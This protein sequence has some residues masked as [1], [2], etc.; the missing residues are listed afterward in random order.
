MSIYKD[1]V[2]IQNQLFGYRKDLHR[3]PELGL[4]LPMT[5]EYIE[6][7][8]REMGY[9]PKRVGGCG[10]TASI[11]KEGGKCFMLR[12]DMD[13]LP[14]QELTD[15]EYKSLN[16]NMH[17]C[18]H[19]CHKASML[20]AAQLLKMHEAELDGMVKFMFQP[21]EE[22][23]EGAAMMIEEGILENPK[24]DA[25]LGL[26]IF[27]GMPFPAGTVAMMGADGIF[28][29][30]DWF[31]VHIKGVGCHGAMPNRGVDP[32]NVMAHILISL[33]TINSREMDPAD[34]IVLTIGQAHSG[35]TSNVIPPDAMISGTLRTVKNETRAEVKKRMEAIVSGVAATFMAEAYIEWGSGCPVLENDRQLHEELKSYLREIDGVKVMDYSENGPAYKTMVSEDFAYIAG[36]VPSTYLLISGG[37]PEEGYC[38]S[39]HHPMAKFDDSSIPVAASVYA[40]SA[41]RWLSEHK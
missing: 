9:E 31:T 1:A 30:V 20:G 28:A 40:Q 12:G 39:Q 34:N 16:G 19:D 13:A 14:V 15:L 38:F 23:M 11:G 33:Q 6:K 36:N 35:S 18:G 17:A 8:L 37:C 26:H 21:A 10:I 2:S 32:I 27:T 41:I 22:T 24:V 5:A 29:A 4:N 3:I 25:A 7:A